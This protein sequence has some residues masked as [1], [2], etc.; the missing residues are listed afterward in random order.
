M[1]K[2]GN[3]SFASSFDQAGPITKNVTDNAI[4][5][6]AMSGFD[7][8]DSTSAKI[9]VPDYEKELGKI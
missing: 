3:Y 9:E 5:L 2:M 8:L 4:M 1:L 7:P 6:K